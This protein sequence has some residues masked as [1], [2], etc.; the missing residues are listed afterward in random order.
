M[1]A[2][3][4]RQLDQPHGRKDTIAARWLKRLSQ[5]PRLRS[6]LPG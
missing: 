3:K 2:D 1:V 5:P 4:L 6:R